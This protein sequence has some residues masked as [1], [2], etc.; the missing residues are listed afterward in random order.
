MKKTVIQMVAIT[1]IVLLV[2]GISTF[3]IVYLAYQN[4]HKSDFT[5]AKYSPLFIMEYVLMDVEPKNI[6]YLIPCCTVV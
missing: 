2:L 1:S 5:L 4:M 6:S 3:L